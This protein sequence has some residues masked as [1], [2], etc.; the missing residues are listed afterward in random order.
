MDL[1]PGKKYKLYISYF[2]GRPDSKDDDT[3]N[4]VW[5]GEANEKGEPKFREIYINTLKD[6]L[7]V[8]EKDK[9]KKET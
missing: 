9:I 5:A 2:L 1:E 3:K 8:K 4:R 6:V 7:E